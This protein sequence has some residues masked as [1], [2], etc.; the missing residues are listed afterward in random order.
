VS[1]NVN[2]SLKSM[3]HNLFR[4]VLTPEKI[5]DAIQYDETIM[6]PAGV[7]FKKIKGSEELRKIVPNPYCLSI[8][9]LYSENLQSILPGIEGAEKFHRLVSQVILR[10]FRGSLRDMDIKVDMFHGLKVID[11]VYAN[12][13]GFF[14]HMEKTFCPYICLRPRITSLILRIRSSTKSEGV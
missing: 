4:G 13:G 14:A 8:E 9:K 3:I 2:E 7:K 11:T 5:V 6:E 1:P 10:I 12:A